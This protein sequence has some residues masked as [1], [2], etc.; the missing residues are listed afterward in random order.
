MYTLPK[1]GSLLDTTNCSPTLTNHGLALGHQTILRQR[2]PPRPR[3][4]PPGLPLQRIPRKIHARPSS[5]PS[6]TPRTHHHPPT[7]RHP[8]NRPRKTRRSPRISLPRRPLRPPLV[9]LPTPLRHRSRNQIRPRETPR[10]I[11]RLQGPESGHWARGAR[12]LRRGAD[13][14]E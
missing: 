12:E 13:Y 10:Y 6:S 8:N 9:H 14:A 2:S 5:S 3:P 4:Q 7:H 1:V 11:R